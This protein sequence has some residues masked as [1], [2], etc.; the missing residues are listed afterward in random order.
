MQVAEKIHHEGTKSA[1]R[2]TKD[3]K[4]RRPNLRS[5]GPAVGGLAQGASGLG[6]VGDGPK[7]AI[8]NRSQS[9]PSIPFWNAN[10]SLLFFVSLHAPEGRL[11]ALSVSAAP[12]HEAYR[13]L[14][15]NR[16]S[17]LH[18]FLFKFLR[19]KTRS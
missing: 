13:N 5:R 9:V 18:I 8:A 11:R 14:V 1:A 10:P 3:T 4:S 7:K 12:I 17:H 16:F 15:V 6:A 2:H 19:R